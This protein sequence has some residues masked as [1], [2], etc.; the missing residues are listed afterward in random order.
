M[1]RVNALSRLNT[2]SAQRATCRTHL[3]SWSSEAG[4]QGALVSRV[5]TLFTGLR[6][7][8]SP[9]V[10]ASPLTISPELGI[11]HAKAIRDF[12]R[13]QAVLCWDSG[14]SGTESD[15][16]GTAV[17]S[18]FHFRIPSSR[19]RHLRLSNPT[20]SRTRIYVSRIYSRAL[21]LS[22]PQ[23][24]EA[25]T[26]AGGAAHSFERKGF[27][28][29][30]GP[31]FF[32]DLSCAPGKSKNPLKQVLDLLGEPLECATYDRWKV[33]TPEGRFDCSTEQENYYRTVRR[34]AGAE[35]LEQWK[36]LEARA[37]SERVQ[38]VVHWK[39]KSEAANPLSL[40]AMLD[41]VCTLAPLRMMALLAPLQA[42][43]T[44]V[45]L[46]A[47][48]I[49]FAALRGDAGVALTIV[50]AL[51]SRECTA[52]SECVSLLSHTFSLPRT[53]FINSGPASLNTWP[54][55]P[56]ARTMCS[57][58]STQGRY[59]GAMGPAFLKLALSS[60][61]PG[62]AGDALSGSL[63]ELMRQAKVTQPWLKQL[64]DLECFVISGCLAEGTPSPEM[65][66]MYKERHR[67][68]AVL[69]FPIGG[70]QAFID[71]LVR[72]IQKRGGRVLL[73]APV[74]GA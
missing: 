60:G 39:G 7:S 28:F 31:S 48:A 5:R 22:A 37:G 8:V 14:L 12:S 52:V 1:Q 18:V 59:L 23:V 46:M 43:L 73:G 66:F 33:Y 71:A 6:T 56:L 27:V 67:P 21:S 61:G 36:A 41:N 68:G 53:R 32:F 49:P 16:T 65:A 34:F 15:G 20:G 54:P 62:G 24:C 64:L 70:S 47:D 50:R 13:A 69:D 45:G 4:S 26:I 42:R 17:C 40:P 35:G 19:I 74:E 38:C 10:V 30:S 3:T 44:P 11:C 29:D 72:G 9:K 51:S 63:A 57:I 2:R 25:H 58:L 55:A